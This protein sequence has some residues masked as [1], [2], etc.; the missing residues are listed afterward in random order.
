[1]D[2][3]SITMTPFWEKDTVACFTICCT[4]SP[5]SVKEGEPVLDLCGSGFRRDRS[6]SG[7]L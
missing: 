7:N 6:F 2:Q 4:M 1:M 3:L 5:F